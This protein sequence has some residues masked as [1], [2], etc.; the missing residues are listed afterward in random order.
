MTR[1]YSTLTETTESQMVDYVAFMSLEAKRHQEV[2]IRSLSASDK[3]EFLKAK[4]KE[5]DQWVSNAVFS[6]VRKA[7]VPFDRI[8]AMRWVLTWKAADEDATERKAKARL[9]VKGFTDPDLATVRAESPTLSRLARRWLLQVAA[10][11]KVETHQ[12]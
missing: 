4:D 5:L 11:S 12:R 1:T 9:V 10:S 2:T 7:G 3:A 8:I 6:I